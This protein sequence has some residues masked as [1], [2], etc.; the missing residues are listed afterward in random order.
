MLA[1]ISTLSSNGSES[2][3]DSSCALTGA[4]VL[5]EEGDDGNPSSTATFP[6]TG[7]GVELIVPPAAPEGQAGGK[8]CG[9]GGSV[10]RHRQG[11]PCT[12]TRT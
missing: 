2:E 4:F 3:E 5:E 11:I 8:V 7:D 6:P 10:G 9:S 12:Q 1:Q